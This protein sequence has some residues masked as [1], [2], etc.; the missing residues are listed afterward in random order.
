MCGGKWWGV[1]G[2]LE[3]R[4]EWWRVAKR[5]NRLTVILWVLWV[6]E[7]FDGGES[8]GEGFGGG[9]GNG[10]R[11]WRLGWA[12]LCGFWVDEEAE[13]K[14]LTVVNEDGGLEKRWWWWRRM[15]KMMN[16]EGER[17]MKKKRVDRCVERGFVEG[18]FLRE[19]LLWGLCVRP[20]NMSGRWYAER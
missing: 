4:S 17:V 2:R 7:G 3:I 12:D 9:D 13:V 11:W 10:W 15:V 1:F 6:C 20:W 8:V 18:F 14:G 16:S 19:F 5:C